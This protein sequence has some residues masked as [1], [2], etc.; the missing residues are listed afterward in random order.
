M[1]RQRFVHQHHTTRPISVDF[2]YR[3]VQ[4]QVM[5]TDNAPAPI[6]HCLGEDGRCAERVGVVADLLPRCQQHRG[7]R[8]RQFDLATVAAQVNTVVM[9]AA[10]LDVSGGQAHARRPGEH[11]AGLTSSGP[12]R[13]FA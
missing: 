1:P 3:Q 10:H 5:K 2:V 7:F 9:Q 4:R 11:R 8:M 12:D 6:R 13:G